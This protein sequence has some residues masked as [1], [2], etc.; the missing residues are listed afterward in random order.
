MCD[1]SHVPAYPARDHISSVLH[2]CW[3]LPIHFILQHGE[4]VV[5]EKVLSGYWGGTNVLVL[6]TPGSYLGEPLLVD[7]VHHHN[8]I[9]KR[10]TRPSR[11]AGGRKP[12]TLQGPSHL[13]RCK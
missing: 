7:M 10:S 12:V 13:H 6:P 5:L 8:L 1:D 2:T 3:Y 4:E 9:V 11:A